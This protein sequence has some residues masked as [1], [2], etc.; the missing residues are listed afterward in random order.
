[1]SDGIDA[2]VIF[3]ATGDLAKIETFPA[4]IGLVKRGVLDV[5]VIGVAKSG[6]GLPQF[7]DYATA[8]LKLNGMD[9]AEPAAVKMLSLLRY[10]DGD[11]DDDATYKAMS[12]EIG[13]GQRVLYYLEVPPVLFGRIAH[14]IASA[15]RA[16]GAR[17]MVEKPFGTDLASA[18]ALNETMHQVFPEDAIYRVHHKL[19][20]V[21]ECA[22]QTFYRDKAL[23]FI[24]DHP[25][26]KAKLAGQAVRMLWD[27]RVQKTEGRPGRGGFID[28]VRT[29]V[30]PV[31][32]IPLY[33]LALGGLFLVPRRIA[34]LIV[35]LLGYQTVVA[36]GFAGDT[37]YRVPWDF[38][39]S[40]A[41][42]AAVLHLASRVVARRAAPRTV[43]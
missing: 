17:V 1:M 29:W 21:N 18:Q 37:R 22:Q 12:D 26:E 15:G 39:L 27:P 7:R 40:L 19:I 31:Y 10:V 20:H 24:V 41:A 9:P 2:L 3:G 13:T 6:W 23:S 42:S 34:V 8:S 32:E 33:L 4:L 35:L 28:R 38:A 25:G 14:G 30:Q 16:R 36:I 43:A 11:L 5:P